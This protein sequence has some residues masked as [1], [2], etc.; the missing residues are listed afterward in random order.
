MRIL[1]YNVISFLMFLLLSGCAPHKQIRM[2]PPLTAPQYKKTDKGVTLKM[3]HVSS[4]QFKKIYPQGLGKYKVVDTGNASFTK[5]LRTM[6]RSVRLLRGTVENSSPHVLYISRKSVSLDVIPSDETYY[7][8]TFF[9]NISF[10][11]LGL[12]APLAL[13]LAYLSIAIPSAII[14]AG[15][16]FCCAVPGATV[17]TIEHLKQVDRKTFVQSTMLPDRQ[18]CIEPN[19]SFNWL[20]MIPVSDYSSTFDVTCVDDHGMEYTF[21]VSMSDRAV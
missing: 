10:I 13:L 18:F 19:E 21:N 17:G 7:Q 5:K 6:K 9:R 11:W 12:C 15:I 20:M 3:S 16:A 2:L 14:P 1:C 4:E 8:N